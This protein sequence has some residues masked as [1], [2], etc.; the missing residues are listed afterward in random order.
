M[1]ITEKYS[2][3]VWNYAYPDTGFTGKIKVYPQDFIVTEILPFQA[4]GTGEHVF[5]QIKKT[6]ENTEYVARLLARH[7]KVR[8][9]DIGFA[10]LKDRHAITSQWFSIWLPGKE[11][12]SWDDLETENIQV[13]QSTRH[14]R[15]LKRGVLLGNQ[16]QILVR[17]FSGNLTTCE[18]QLNTIKTQGFPNYFG[19][20]RFG[21][22]GQNIQTALELFAGTKKL[23]RSQRGIYLSAAR[24][25]LFNQ[26]LSQRVQQRQ[27]NQGL[28][29]DACMHSD[30]NSY[31]KAETLDAE[32]LS[33]IAN[34]ELHPTGC[35]YGQ[36]ELPVTAATWKLETEILQ[37]YPELAAGLIKFELE[38]DRRSLRVL[39]KDLHWQ[40]L[41]EQQ[42]LQLNF[43]LPAGSY[44]T[45][46]VREIIPTIS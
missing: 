13:L 17:D 18:Q 7:A 44:A 6:S 27:W 46:L 45:A 42:Q 36:G 43:F 14:Q 5:V 28:D 21:R 41:P 10:G 34:A 19:S 30:S 31:F 15:K 3:P 2:I 26:I 33:R 9:R 40:F 32:L 25:Y 35:L 16:F 24:A 4:T 22:Q 38:M 20:Q 39:A 29:G 12:P 11:T 37:Q 8:S 23:K 1:P